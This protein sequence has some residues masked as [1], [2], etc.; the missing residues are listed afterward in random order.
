MRLGM[1]MQPGHFPDHSVKAGYDYDLSQISLLEKLGYEEVWL[2]EHFTSRYENN[3]APDLLI[4]QALLQT[5]KIKLAV[6]AHALPYHHPMELACRIAALDHLAQGRLMMGVGSGA[7]PS[8]WAA[9]NVDGMSGEHRA[10]AR[11]SLE[12]MKKLWTDKTPWKYEGKFWTVNRIPDEWGAEGKLGWHMYP[13]QEPHP[14]IAMAGFSE[15]SGTLKIAGELGHIPMSL[16]MNKRYMG[17]HWDAVEEGAAKTGLT[18]NR[19]DWRVVKEVFVAKTDAEARKYGVDGELGRYYEEY[20]LPLYRAFGFLG[21]MKHDDSVDDKD[22]TVEYLF[23]HQWAIGS[24]DTVAEKLSDLQEECGGFE[25]LLVLGI[26]YSANPEPW[27]NS[28]KLLKEQVEPQVI[29]PSKRIETAA[30]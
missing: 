25:T 5:S 12:I 13:F 18:P 24:P 30:R 16:S 23:E 28:L 9:F 2:G 27:A 19:N 8:D 10:M 3:P 7:I 29:S 21:H 17:S 6:G 14:P 26:D 4:A 20:M 11:E 1:F 22:V 15:R